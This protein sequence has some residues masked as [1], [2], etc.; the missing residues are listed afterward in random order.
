VLSVVTVPGQTQA[1]AVQDQ[2]TQLLAH[3]LP[4]QAVVVVVVKLVL[5]ALVVQAAVAQEATTAL[6]LMELQTQAAVVV[7]R[8]ILWAAQML[9]VVDQA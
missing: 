3:L 8:A 7:D 6:E 1:R 4:T 5:R 2:Q 9:Q